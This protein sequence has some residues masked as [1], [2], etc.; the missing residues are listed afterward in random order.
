MEQSE[1]QRKITSSSI[2]REYTR[3]KQKSAEKEEK[4]QFQ[5]SG[6]NINHKQKTKPKRCRHKK[7]SE[8]GDAKHRV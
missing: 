7:P 2:R 6:D 5:T 1:Y 4:H 8:K 3:K